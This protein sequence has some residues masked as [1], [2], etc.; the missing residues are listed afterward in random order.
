MRE[1]ERDRERERERWTEREGGS[2]GTVHYTTSVLL[3]NL[4]KF[5]KKEGKSIIHVYL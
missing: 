2:Y 1:I 5:M 3:L 4:A